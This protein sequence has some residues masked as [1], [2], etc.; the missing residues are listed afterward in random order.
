[1]RGGLWDAASGEAAGRYY[2]DRPRVASD[3]GRTRNGSAA[4]GTPEV[5]SL[6]ELKKALEKA[7]PGSLIRLASGTYQIF[8]EDPPFLIKGVQG[9]PDQP[10]VIQGTHGPDQ[11]LRATIIDGGRSLDDTLELEEHY[12]SPG[13]RPIE[14]HELIMERRCRTQHAINC[15]LFEETAYLVVEELTVRNCWPTGL[16][17]VSSRY[18]T[19]RAVNAVGSTYPFFADRRSDHFLVEDNVWTQDPSGY[20]ADES[21]YS[22]RVD[23]TPK[24]GRM[25]DTIPWGG[26]SRLSSLPQRRP[27]RQ[28]WH[29]RQYRHPPQHHPQRL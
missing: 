6:Q 18:V 3:G 11:G 25:W 7:T 15:F 1:M 4:Q 27:D 28:L 20:T 17:F 5:S 9:L 13:S 29:S 8:A 12:R 21:G 26:A 10:I 16:I 24:P 2:R 22:G 14:L 23:L 19:L